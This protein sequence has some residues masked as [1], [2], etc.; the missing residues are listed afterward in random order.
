[1][2]SFDLYNILAVKKGLSIGAIATN[3]TT[4]GDWIDLTG[5]YGVLWTILSGTITDGTF[6]PVLYEADL[7]DQSD[8]APVNANFVIGKYSDATFAASDDNVAKRI[9]YVGKKKYAQLR[10]VSN[11]VT[12]GGTLSASAQIGIP[13]HAPTDPGVR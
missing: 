12:T 6:T 1:M 4:N 2:A 9:G 10:I 13:R 5:S 11:G 8:A 3:T 7:D